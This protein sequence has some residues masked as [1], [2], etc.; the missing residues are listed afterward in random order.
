MKKEI[1]QFY[2]NCNIPEKTYENLK[3]HCTKNGLKKNYAVTQAIDKYL[4][5]E[6]ADKNLK[7]MLT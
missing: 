4:A 2:V 5:E 6:K 3:G 7:K 1:K